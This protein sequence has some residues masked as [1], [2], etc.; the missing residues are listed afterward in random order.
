MPVTVILSKTIS[1]ALQPLGAGLDVAMLLGDGCAQPLQAFDVQIDGAR[2]DRASAGQGNAGASAARDQRAQHQRRGAH[3]L[4]QFIG[5]FGVARLSTADGSAMLGAAIAQFD[6][7]AHGGQQL[8]LGL[9]V[10]HLGDV[11][12]DDR[13]IG[14]QRRRHG[15]QRGVLRAADANGPSSGLP[16]R[17]TN[18][19]ISKLSL[20]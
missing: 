1:R 8:A 9:D 15:G 12:Q 13:L 3:G 17:I 6:L 19:S 14:E 10:A 2:A 16:P 18:L 20:R 11:F 7:G 4:D 5:G